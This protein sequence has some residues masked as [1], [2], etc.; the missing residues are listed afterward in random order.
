M[1]NKFD[2][3]AKADA[4]VS[5]YQKGNS[6]TRHDII[7]KRVKALKPTELKDL[8][9]YFYKDEVP[10]DHNDL[11]FLHILLSYAI[12][13]ESGTG[14]EKEVELFK[15]KIKERLAKG[16]S[17]SE[18]A[19][20]EDY[21]PVD[22]GGGEMETQTERAK[23]KAKAKTAAPKKE[24]APRAKK[25]ADWYDK[26]TKFIATPDKTNYKANKLSRPAMVC[27]GLNK[28]VTMAKLIEKYKTG[29]EEN[30]LAKR[31][32]NLDT[33]AAR[34]VPA[35][36]KWMLEQKAVKVYKD[37]DP[38]EVKV[39]EKKPAKKKSAGKSAEA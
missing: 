38:T 37:G 4:F 14:T 28:P 39:A 13:L 22:D 35:L 15:N 24:S 7:S 34:F 6:T 9:I 16:P 32:K 20:E 26:D 36:V 27:A 17:R 25:E 18:K 1:S 19:G 21:Q 12:V 23:A 11:N 10:T 31:I 3:Q 29:M 2:A 8:I 30:G 33:Q 5:E